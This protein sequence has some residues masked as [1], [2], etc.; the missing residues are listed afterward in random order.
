VKWW[1]TINE[2][3]FI[4]QAYSMDEGKAPALGSQFSG[5]TD[6]MAVRNIVLS[7]AAAYRIYEKFYKKKQKGEAHVEVFPS[8]LI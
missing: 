1:T 3:R 8:F 2:P 4:V 5:I 6:Y 7:H